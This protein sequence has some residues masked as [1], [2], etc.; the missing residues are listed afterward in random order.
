MRVFFLR[1]VFLLS[2]CTAFQPLIAQIHDIAPQ[3]AVT[4]DE[5]SARLTLNDASSIFSIELSA[6]TDSPLSATFTAKIVDP[7]EKVIAQATVPVQLTR[8]AQRVQMALNWIPKGSLTDTVTAR[9]RYEVRI[10]NDQPP[11]V[12]GTLSPT[13]IIPDLFE[14]RFMGLEFASAA[15]TYIAHVWATRPNSSKPVSGVELTGW[16]GDEDDATGGIR[17]QGRTNLHGEATL[18]FHLP[19]LPP[20]G[21]EEDVDLEIRGKRA[22]FQNSVT[23]TL[24]LWEH[25]AILLSTDKPLYQPE[26][27]LHMRALLLDDQRHAWGQQPVRFEA[28]DPDDAVVFSADAKSSRFGIASSEWAIPASQKLGNYRVSV[29]VSGDTD[30][31]ELQTDQRVR[32]SRY[33]LPTF[34]VNVTTDHPTICP[35]RT[36]KWS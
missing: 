20:V 12:A 3:P 4:V 2:L 25:A 6:A 15:N 17:A 27:V 5:G 21:Q 23:G 11:T 9:V 34:T 33:E 10:G 28:R 35:A 24:K 14:L 31:K 19:V 18:S 30:S 36:P 8:Q 1:V 22:G 7:D 16:L 13:A 29:K 26:Q 32:I